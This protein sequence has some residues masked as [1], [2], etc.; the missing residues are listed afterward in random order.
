MRSRGLGFQLL[1]TSLDASVSTICHTHALFEAEPRFSFLEVP[2][3][4]GNSSCFGRTCYLQ[5]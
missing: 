4:F 1:L 2:R 5:N 3:T